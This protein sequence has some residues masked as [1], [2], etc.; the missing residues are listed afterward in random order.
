MCKNRKG[1]TLI[2][3]LIVITIIG[4]LAVAFLPTL[5]GAPAKGRDTQRIADL[6]KLQ[7]VMVNADLEGKAYPDD[8]GC[9]IS[10]EP[11]DS[12]TIK[13]S[14]YV[15]A[16]GGALPVPPREED[17]KEI[18]CE[19]SYG[20]IYEPAGYKFALITELEG[21]ENANTACPATYDAFAGL[22]AVSATS[23]PCYA[24]LTQ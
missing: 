3:L 14:E 9:V 2:E 10:S 7:K 8:S 21:S 6:Q 11:A 22:V 18:N 16:L 23:E 17:N 19:G 12:T 1:F 20:Y 5:L 24:I 4:I 13:F 15:T